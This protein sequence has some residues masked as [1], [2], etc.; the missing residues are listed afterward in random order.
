MA[1]EG[2][3]GVLRTVR[4]GYFTGSGTGLIGSTCSAS[5]SGRVIRLRSLP[6]FAAAGLSFET[7]A[8]AM[9][10]QPEAVKLDLEARKAIERV[11]VGKRLMFRLRKGP[12]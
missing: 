12:R 11:R 3:F 8:I 4:P 9:S 2:A 5:R 1:P 7:A 10:R 6:K